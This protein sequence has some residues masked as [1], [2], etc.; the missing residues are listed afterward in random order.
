MKR[1]KDFIYK[2]PM[3][4]FFV[5]CIAINHIAGKYNEPSLNKGLTVMAILGLV[6]PTLKKK[7]ILK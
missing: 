2:H 6:L 5:V 7:G 1:I 3:F 4:I